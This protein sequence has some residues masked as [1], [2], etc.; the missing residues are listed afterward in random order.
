M[1]AALPPEAPPAASLFEPVRDRFGLRLALV[2]GNHAPGGL[3]PYYAAALC[4]H[5]DIGAGEGRA[6]A[7]DDNRRRL[8]FFRE[9]YAAVLPEV[10][11]LVLYNSGSVLSPRELPPDLL[12]W[13]L[14]WARAA[15]PRL[16]AVS[17][18]SRE[19]YITRDAVLRVARALGPGIEARPILGLETAD[20]RLRDGLLEKR[21]PLPAVRRAFAAAGEAARRLGPERVGLDVN[22][23][24]AGPGTAPATAVPDAV[25]TARFALAEGR[26]AGVP[27]DLNLHPYYPSARGLARFPAHPRCP[28]ALAAA[29]AGAIAALRDALAPGAGVFLGWQDE[30]H[31]REPERRAEELARAQAA[32][33]RFNRTQDA[34]AL[35]TLA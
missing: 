21:M 31:D 19:P 15:S 7:A 9:R 12:D 2:L 25:A 18:D 24:V 4:H 10:A 29:A 6:F 26:A 32:F 13:A 28:P 23:V 27:V 22:V 33:D 20:D 1:S 14:A 17:L 8:A 5:C 34:G 16:R 30:G 35:G 3:C 11:H